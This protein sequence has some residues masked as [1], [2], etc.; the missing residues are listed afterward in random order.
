MFYAKLS[1]TTAEIAEIARYPQT[2]ARAIAWLKEN[3]FASLPLGKTVVAGEEIFISVAEY[4]T[5][6]GKDAVLEAHRKYADIQLIVSGEELMSAVPCVPE[7]P[8]LGDGYDE[9]RDVVFF[10][11]EVMPFWTQ[12]NDSPQ[13]IL[14][15]SG[16]FCIFMPEDVHASQIFATEPVRTKKLVVKCRV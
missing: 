5:K 9:E 14:V 10:P 8:V 16:E 13:K 3:D 6:P 2:V 12:K 7:L 4:W 15:K 11:P 1:E